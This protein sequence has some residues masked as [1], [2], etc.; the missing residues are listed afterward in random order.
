MLCILKYFYGY[1]II[2]IICKKKKKDKL[3]S[4]FAPAPMCTYLNFF[5][6]T[7]IQTNK[8]LKIQHVL[9]FAKPTNLVPQAH[10]P[11][12]HFTCL[13]HIDTYYCMS[14]I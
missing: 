10:G 7:H 1:N 12:T 9:K 14:H 8:N 4:K 13:I 6:Y 3:V 2:K 5:I 11:K